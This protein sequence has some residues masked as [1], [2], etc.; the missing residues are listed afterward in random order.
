MTHE[1]FSGIDRL[2]GAGTVARLARAHVAVIGIGGVGS[3]V[4]EALARSGIGELTLI[5]ADDICL[6]NT[7]RQLHALDGAYGR[8]KVIAMAERA[9]A[10]NPAIRVAPR[11]EF[12][13]TRN[14]ESMLAHRYSYVVDA[15][16]ALAIK[17]D[18]IAFL[19]RRKTP[20]ITIGAAGGRLDPRRVDV[21]D[22]AKTVHDPLLAEVRRAL[23]DEYRWTRNPK[24]F[25]GVQAV[26]SLEH[27]RFVQADGRV[28][29]AR[30]GNAAA[31]LKLDCANALGSATHV[32]AAF[33]MV[34]TGQVIER[35]LGRR[36]V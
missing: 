10:I 18:A 20:V 7:N 12:L 25:F 3:W 2:Y 8:S 17:V 13:S 1:R 4:V 32:T 26:Y 21:R 29:C 19:K 28:S 14:L 16:D 22:L 23:R 35:L 5:D 24:R 30:V 27:P 33:A 11:A 36:I 31:S 34:A 6:S 15:C 9:A